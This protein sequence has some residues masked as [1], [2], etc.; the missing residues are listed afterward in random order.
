[1]SST[2][3]PGRP[4]DSRRG[5]GR[6][7]EDPPESPESSG[8]TLCV[9]ATIDGERS[10][11]TV[12]GLARIEDGIAQQR[13][14]ALDRRHGLDAAA[15]DDDAHAGSITLVLHPERWIGWT[16]RDRSPTGRHGEIAV[17]VSRLWRSG[18]PGS[19]LG[20]P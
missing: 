16:D 6:S 3:A 19:T 20:S 17:N 4:P 11:V 2:A 14:D 15:A 9:V 5:N 13:F 18:D 12:E 8:A 10:Y 1:M 7:A